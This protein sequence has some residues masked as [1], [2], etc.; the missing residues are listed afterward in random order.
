MIY[1]DA[2]FPCVAT[3]AFPYDAKCYMIADTLPEL[4]AFA[5]KLEIRPMQC[6]Q[7]SYYLLK[8]Q[9]AAAIKA[10]ACTD[11]DEFRKCWATW[12]EIYARNKA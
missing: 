2:L 9:R 7:F 11:I 6:K 3:S 1:V 4:R 8:W 12:K 10:G 5:E